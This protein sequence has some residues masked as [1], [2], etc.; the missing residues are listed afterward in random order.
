[1]GGSE[2]TLPAARRP[3]IVTYW[4]YA[5]ALLRE[6]RW[7][8]L[9]LVVVV[10]LGS[11]FYVVTPQ[12]ALGGRRPD[13][14]TSLYASWMALFGQAI[15]NPPGTWYLE[16]VQGA[17]PLL[18]IA[19]VGEGLVRFAF[20][21]TSRR[22]GERE[23]MKVMASTYRDHVVLCGLGHLGFRVLELLHQAGTPVVA[24]ER[25]PN[26]RF[27]P[28]ARELGI[29]I[30]LH[31]MREDQALI[32]AGMEHARAVVIATNDDMANLEVALDARRMNPGIRVILRMF[33]RKVAAKIKEA[34]RIDEAFSSASLAAPVVAGMVLGKPAS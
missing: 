12:V 16:V 29:P 26:A 19:L 1:M 25:D 2:G 10:L 32:D 5:R 27:L 33:D 9:A 14:F 4:L 18:G 13:F 31:D 22:R 3:R 6:F 21:M 34:F 15:F 7:T 23:W 30:F 11:V 8:L 24:L 17:G 20:L 28:N